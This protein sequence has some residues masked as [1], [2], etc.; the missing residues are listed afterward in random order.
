MCAS[1]AHR[2]Q[3]ARGSGGS[4]ELDLDVSTL[5]LHR[6]TK[7]D[8][9]YT[10]MHETHTHTHTWMYV[11]IRMSVMFIVF[12]CVSSLMLSLL[13]E[14]CLSAYSS[15]VSLGSSLQVKGVFGV[16]LHCIGFRRY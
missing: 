10:H 4:E 16:Y 11:L 5:S 13:W 3:E 1:V 12:C 2:G 6:R 15:L 9:R 8:C 14:R 7:P